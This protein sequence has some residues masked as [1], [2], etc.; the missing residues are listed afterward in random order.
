MKWGCAAN[1]VGLPGVFT[2]GN[3]ALSVCTCLRISTFEILLACQAD[4]ITALLAPG[5]VCLDRPKIRVKWVRINRMDDAAV[6]QPG[7]ARGAI[8]APQVCAGEHYILCR[9]RQV[10]SLDG[11]LE[12]GGRA[13]HPEIGET[14]TGGRPGQAGQTRIGAGKYFVGLAAIRSHQPYLMF[15][16]HESDIRVVG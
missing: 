8:S 12:V 5:R 10:A 4:I 11:K 14:L 3:Q 15:S 6:W 2:H 13:R 1:Q 16:D 9:A 7:D